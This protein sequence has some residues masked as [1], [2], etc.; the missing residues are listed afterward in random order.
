MRLA[1]AVSFAVCLF[2]GLAIEAASAAERHAYF[3]KGDGYVRY[4][5]DTDHVDVGPAP[6]AQFWTHLPKEFQSN[7][8]AVVNW[9]DGHA[10]FF[11]GAGYLR[12]NID[13]DHVDVGPAPIAQ[14]W[15]HLPTEFQ[16]NLD[17]TVNW[18]DGHAYF[19]KG[20]GYLRYNIDTDHVDV[21]PAP[22]AQ[23]WTHLPKEF[24]SNLDAVV[25]WGD[26]HAYF[27]KGARY[28]RYNIDTDHVDVGPDFIARFWTHLPKEFQ[29][30]LN[31]VFEWNDGRAVVHNGLD[32]GANIVNDYYLFAHRDTDA[33]RGH[34]ETEAATR[35]FRTLDDLLDHILETPDQTHV[36]V[37]HGSPEQGLLIR[38]RRTSKLDATG[39]VLGG[40]A[41]LVDAFAQATRPLSDDKLN[42]VASATG[43]SP[44][45]VRELVA[46]F[47]RVQERKPILH[48]RGCNLGRNTGTLADLK[49][50]F[51]AV[52]I[53]APNCRM[54]YIRINPRAQSADS[55]AR[56]AAHGNPDPK[57]RRRSF[58]PPSTSS[59]GPLLIDVRDK[60]GHANVD[61]PQS[62]IVRRAEVP[63][64]AEFLLGRWEGTQ[65]EFVLPILWEDTERSFHCPLEDGYRKRLVDVH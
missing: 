65:G 20:E 14:F 7:L 2:F 46:K 30:N 8:D 26:G 54:L 15:T 41:D 28:L 44:F 38:F 19:F 53:T 21:G 61:S 18:G 40:I 37:A 22:I 56:L 27:F 48:F 25:N 39:P 51:G 63:T 62:F 32:D 6:V 1:A 36:I 12:Y 47:A 59:V 49:R 45:E 57:T 31:A 10:Y 43:L 16:S 5:I 11:K 3:F 29:S 50:V 33:R 23:F 4:N 60:D 34:I 64:W 42:K 17:A 58:Q 52:R 9:G 24:Q 13:T 35:A 55:I